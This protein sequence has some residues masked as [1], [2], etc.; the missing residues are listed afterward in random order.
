MRRAVLW[1]TGF[2]ALAASF[3]ARADA[4]QK[5]VDEKF[6]AATALYQWD[7]TKLKAMGDDSTV[8]AVRAARPRIDTHVMDMAAAAARM[9]TPPAKTFV[10][11]TRKLDK[12][13]DFVPADPDDA[14]L[15]QVADTIRGDVMDAQ[16]ALE[17]VAAEAGCP[18]TPPQARKVL[19]LERSLRP[20][21][22]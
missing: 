15:K 21:S 8:A 22:P 17:Q 3:A 6:C 18:P 10:E 19:V 13:I 16:M 12:D 11:A 14:T 20:G 7:I 5:M 1:T 4:G 2:I 9:R